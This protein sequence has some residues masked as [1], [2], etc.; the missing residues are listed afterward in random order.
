MNQI[1]DQSGKF[2]L[3]TYEKPVRLISVVPSLTELLFDLGLEQNLI[4][5]TRFCIHPKPQVKNLPIIG[6]TKNL[7]IDKIVELQPSLIIANK[8]ENTKEQIYQISTTVPVWVS[9][10]M[11]IEDDL[12]AILTIADLCGASY[13]GQKLYHNKKSILLSLRNRYLQLPKIKVLYMIWR[14]PYMGVASNTYIHSMLEWLGFANVLEKYNRYPKLLTSDLAVLEPD[15]IFL[16]SEPYPFNHSHVSEFSRLFPNS[17]IILVNGELFSWY[18]SR[19]LHL[20]KE[21]DYLDH[22]FESTL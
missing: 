16:S 14:D 2:S 19:L 5:R 21:I 11:T 4:G 13:L 9:D 8:E 10:I 7:K 22:A 18:G 15:I 20:Q 1:L 17:K 6:G 12:N 3:L